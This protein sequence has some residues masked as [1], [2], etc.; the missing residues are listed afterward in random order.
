MQKLQASDRFT[1]LKDGVA[2][3]FEVAEEGGPER[4]R[5]EGDAEGGERRQRRRGG[6]RRQKEQGRENQ[7]RRRAVNI[8][9]EVLDGRADEARKQHL[10]RAVDGS[11]GD[12]AGH[13][14][15]I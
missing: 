7:Y 11:H 12:P 13:G 15:G 6:V 10:P 3:E 14:C 8:E 9:V 5:E 4:S 2:F 1:I